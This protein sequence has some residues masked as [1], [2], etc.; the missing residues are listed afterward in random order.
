[1]MHGI[2][3]LPVIA[4]LL[5]FTSWHER[6]RLDIV[7]LATLAYVIVVGVV[8]VDNVMSPAG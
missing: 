5:S 6:R 2:L 1:M 8:A 4:R 3:A 7:L